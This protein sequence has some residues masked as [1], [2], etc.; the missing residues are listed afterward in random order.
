MSGLSLLWVGV[1]CS[2]LL[3]PYECNLTYALFILSVNLEGLGVLV[4]SELLSNMK[5]LLIERIFTENMLTAFLLA[6]V[7]TGPALMALTSSGVYAF[8]NFQMLA[9]RI[10]MKIDA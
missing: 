7:P 4:L 2:I 3:P 9:Q 6:N 1:C 10:K 8:K 5:L